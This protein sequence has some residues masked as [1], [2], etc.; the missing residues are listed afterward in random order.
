MNMEK[1]FAQQ[2]ILKDRIGYNGEDRFEKL[3]LALLVEL[4]ECAN[5]WRGFKFWSKNQE[6]RNRTLE[7]YVDGL[8]FVLEIGLEHEFDPDGLAIEELKY[9]TIT[10]Q[11]TALFKTDWEIYEEGCGG[12]F[13]EGL[14]LYIGLGGML[15]F[16]WEQI[17]QAYMDKN[18]VNH[19][20][21]NNGY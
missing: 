21:Q 7:E 2:Q 12:Y 13:H 8:H 16:T 6:P 1:L 10:R 3:V 4:G 11:F 5:E 19:E 14:E 15:G 17:E 20:R 18:A 9:P